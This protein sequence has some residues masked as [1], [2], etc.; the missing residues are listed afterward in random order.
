[1]LKQNLLRK[2][3]EREKEISTFA[4]YVYV[5]SVF[6]YSFFFPEKNSASKSFLEAMYKDVKTKSNKNKQKPCVCKGAVGG[7]TA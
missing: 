4:F 3:G 2:T 5:T 7:A 1:M 6:T